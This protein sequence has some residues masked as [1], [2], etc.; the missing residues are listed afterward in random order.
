MSLWGNL[1]AANN[2]PKHGDT[3]GY[4][5]NTPQVTANTQ[6]YYSNTRNGA[7][8]TGSAIGVFGV[9]AQEQIN[10][11]ASANTLLG[12]PQHAGW[13]IR[14]TG[15]G[16]ITAITA[17]AAAVGANSFII[18]SQGNGRDGSGNTAAVANIAVNSAG[19]ITTVSLISGGLYANT[20]I[21]TANSGNASFTITMGG[22]AN[23]VTTE[24][25]VAMG[26]I[27]EVNAG[28]SVY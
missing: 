20:P 12:V 13:V 4:G 17:N 27:T 18:F 7:F 11:E 19:Y 6:V 26:T 8:I 1:D 15:M 9:D 23:R 22:R 25:I 10:A 14:K 5:G 16:P 3:A 21:A 2:A 24:T 28:S